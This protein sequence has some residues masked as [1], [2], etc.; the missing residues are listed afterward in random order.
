MR[1]T[2]VGI[3]SAATVGG[4][5]RFGA[6]PVGSAQAAIPIGIAG[7]IAAGAA[8]KYLLDEVGNPL[9]YIGETNEDYEGL[10]ADATHG[11]LRQNA[12]SLKQSNEAVLGNIENLLTASSNHVIAQAKKA[13]I[14][15]LNSGGDNTSATDA[16]V[17][18]VDEFYKTQQ[19]N[20]ISY[21][22]VQVEKIVLWATEASNTS[23]LSMSDVFGAGGAD[24]ESVE[25]LDTDI[26]L[27]DGS[28]YSYSRL[29][30]DLSDGSFSN[31]YF[32]G[33]TI[34]DIYV[35]PVESGENSVFMEPSRFQELF[36]DIESQHGE[37]SSEM[38][39]WVNG[40]ADS[41]Q[42]GD[43][44]TADMISANDLIGD[45]FQEGNNT[46]AGASLASMGLI[47]SQFGMTIQLL[48]TDQ[49]VEGTIYHQDES[50]NTLSQ[51]TEYNPN[52]DIT[53]TVYIAYQ[54]GD[55]SGLEELDQPFIIEEIRDSEGNNQD[56]AS[57][58][59]SN[60]QTYNTELEEVQKELD[61]VTE[62]RQRLEDERDAVATNDDGAG[63]GGAGAGFFGDGGPSVG[64]IA[65]VL[66]VGGIAYALFGQEGS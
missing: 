31:S 27:V 34:P 17:S 53:G 64:A 11:Q 52:N 4:A 7:G 55:S 6:S 46:W 16:A 42:S 41:Y 14:D 61:Q 13:A 51:G 39:T 2:A 59:Q 3:G 24:Y 58:E 36:Q 63:A 29:N 56:Y 18:E 5:S 20:L 48:E 50:I 66:G 37:V 33:T 60:Q 23:T 40:V 45:S 9:D 44:D 10:E 65:A 25:L 22:E 38:S 43:I 15:E 57:F 47:G 12:L 54:E 35:K 26:G 1:A 32:D 49:T 28:A 19:I 8:A 30:A 21:H 62:L